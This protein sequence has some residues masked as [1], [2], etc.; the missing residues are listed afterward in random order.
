LSNKNL[1]NLS[2]GTK[3][4]VGAVLAFL[5]NPKILILD[6]PTAG[7]DPYSSTVLKEKIKNFQHQEKIII[8]TSHIISEL[9]E[10]V[11]KIMYI[12]EGELHFFKPVHIL[13]LETDES[14]LERA[15]AQILNKQTFYTLNN[16]NS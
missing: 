9:E 14:V 13:K 7:L 3:Q 15:L 10:L 4:K 12:I 1:G 2:G 5:F 6:E 8:V 11:S 16:A